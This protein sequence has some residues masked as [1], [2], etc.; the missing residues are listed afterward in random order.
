MKDVFDSGETGKRSDTKGSVL[1]LHGPGYVPSERA[2]ARAIESYYGDFGKR[3]QHFRLAALVLYVACALVYLG[4]RLT[5]FNPQAPVFSVV[6]YGAELYGFLMSL[7]IVMTSWRRKR[8]TVKRAQRGLAV[9]VFIPTLNEPLDVIRRT[10]LGAVHMEY[11]HETWVLDDGNRVEVAA[12]ADELGCRYLARTTN[13]G[14]KAGNL[15][16]GLRHATG[17]FVAVFDADHVPQKDFLDR[18]LGYFNDE[19]VAFVQTPQDY[20][21]LESFQH[22]RHKRKGLIWHEQ[23]FFHYV[24]QTGR[25]HWNAA[26]FCGCSAILRRSALDAIGGF[27]SVTVTEDMHAAVKLQKLGYDTAFHAE[28]LAFG[29]AP[30]DFR[31]FARQRLRWGEGNMQV[32]RE[33]GIPFTRSLTLA[34]RLCYFALTATY[35]DGWQKAVYYITPIIVLFTQVPPIW[36]DF[37]VFL[38]FFVPYIFATYFYYEEYGRGFGN[39]FA[40]EAYAMARVGAAIVST[41]GLVRKRIKF[42]ITS[43]ELQGRMPLALVLP[44]LVVLVG[45]AGGIGYTVLRP[46]IGMP[47]GMPAGIT[48]V[49]VALAAVNCAMAAWVIRD[50]WRSSRAASEQYMHPVPLPVELRTVGGDVHLVEVDEISVCEFVFWADKGSFVDVGDSYRG[51]LYLPGG[52]VPFEA[53]V[54]ERSRAGRHHVRRVRCALTWFTQADEDT[55][56][57]ALHAGRWYRPILGHRESIRTPSEIFEDLLIR[58]RL[59]AQANPKWEPAVYRRQ[60]GAQDG[61]GVCF[62]AKDRTLPDSVLLLTFGDL[63]AGTILHVTPVGRQPEF[64][65]SFRVGEQQSGVMFDEAAIEV[66]DGRI[67]S[68][69]AAQDA[70]AVPVRAVERA[71]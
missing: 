31:G 36:S 10:A 64:S 34:Q 7:L 69:S 46:W 16:N 59:R 14:A 48:V 11:P 52:P 19:N 21:N 4:W 70:S 32:C 40:T 63:N 22:G 23:S 28:P 44:Q 12:L 38:A 56:D 6:F 68:L 55:V 49:I 65:K 1:Q 17:D 24:G 51:S 5:I 3:R 41:F 37:S 50:A 13:E 47:L 45:S 25:D 61:V 35:I 18:L 60:S 15:N 39:I 62:L 58:G 20:F 42:R 26:T 8:R 30:S 43:K 27:P 29:I 54:T 71:S 66:V 53:R 2:G 57:L 9:D 33:E 67:Y